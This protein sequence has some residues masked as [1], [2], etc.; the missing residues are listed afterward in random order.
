MGNK[1]TL[2][3]DVDNQMLTGVLAGIAKKYNLNLEIL[4]IVYSLITFFFAIGP[5]VIIYIIM[6][7]IMPKDTDDDILNNDKNHVL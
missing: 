5:G 2:T 4:K 6:A 1:K 7:L 3:R